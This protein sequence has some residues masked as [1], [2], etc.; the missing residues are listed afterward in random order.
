MITF[1]MIIHALVCIL[2]ACIILMQSGRGGGLTE[3]FASA[4]NIFGAQTNT[5]LVKTTTILAAVF[6]LTC[7]GLAVM[8]SKKGKSLMSDKVA[9]PTKSKV[10]LPVEPAKS[11]VNQAVNQAKDQTAQTAATVES[12]V[13]Q[14]S[15]A[16]ESAAKET[17]ADAEKV[18]PNESPSVEMPKSAVPQPAA[19]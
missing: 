11:D 14:A 8:H 3:Q 4:E 16:V 10:N 9:L 2:L 13:K 1:I 6:L 19:Q 18:M 12:N 15:V 7:L 5:L 17:Q